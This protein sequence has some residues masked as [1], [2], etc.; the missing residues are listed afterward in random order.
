MWRVAL[1]CEDK[2]PHGESK[3]VTDR[4]A[5]VWWKWS[6]SG[7]I[8][9]GERP[10]PRSP[11]Q[12]G[13]SY[14]PL[15][16]SVSRT[17]AHIRHIQ[18]QVLPLRRRRGLLLHF[19][20][21]LLF[22]M[23]RVSGNSPKLQYFFLVSFRLIAKRRVA[24]SSMKRPVPNGLVA[25]VVTHRN[26][27]RSKIRMYRRCNSSFDFTSKLATLKSHSAPSLF[28]GLFSHSVSS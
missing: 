11:N 7:F 27:S 24:R 22:A 5:N 14:P 3:W 9:R 10:R 16:R 15:F 4:R 12:V 21:F 17:R 6:C 13:F 23:P 1:T 28:P 25:M 18:A 20:Y 19:P 2:Q 26:S 8:V